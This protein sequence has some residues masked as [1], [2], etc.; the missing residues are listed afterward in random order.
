MAKYFLCKTDKNALSYK[1]GE[2][3]VFNI[4]ARENCFDIS[5]DKIHWRLWTDD[6]GFFEGE[7]SSSPNNP[8]KVETV[9]N[10]P[11]FAHIFCEYYTP[12]GKLDTSI[13][14]VDASAGAEIEKLSYCDTIP[15][16]FDEY[17]GKIEKK[18]EDFTPEIVKWDEVETKKG[19]KTYD[20]RIT[21]PCETLASGYITIPEKEGNFPMIVGF[22]GYGVGGAYKSYREDT[23]SAV[24]NAHGFENHLTPEELRAKY[25]ELNL[26]G[27]NEEENASN[28]T[29]YF[30]N[31]MIRNLVAVKFLKTLP[32]W[33]RKGLMAT[34]GSQGAFQATTLAAHDKDITFLEIFVP[35]FCNLNAVG[36]GYM[37]GWRPK[38]AEGLRYFDTVAQGMRVKCPTKITAYLGDSCCPASTIVTLYNS[39]NCPKILNMYQAGTH[40]K[41]PP[42]PEK[43]SFFSDSENP[44]NEVITGK[45]RHF[46]GNNYEVI[47]KA[48]DS[49][50]MEE[51]VIY[52]ALYGE[53]ETWVRPKTMFNEFTEK[54]CLAVKR[55]TKI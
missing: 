10:R 24:F 15:K 55:F 13:D 28:E 3:I 46:K 48:F 30:R 41:R 36:C 54:N 47:G 45:Y 40:D 42:E 53:G 38:F 23:I 6:G 25:P 37:D 11:G 52:K 29:T 14:T 12:D 22:Q 51:M 44:S 27:F 8:L 43:F 1:C 5:C 19:F 49:E 34:G 21:T 17:W 4:S 26:Y 33:N 32:Q 20:I 39:M 35:W 31:M 16:D 7:G 2:K 50:T 18:I 9:L